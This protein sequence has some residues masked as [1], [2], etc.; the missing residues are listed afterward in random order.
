M[1]KN[2]FEGYKIFLQKHPSY[3]NVIIVD[4]HIQIMNGQQ[5]ITKIR[6]FERKHNLNY[7]IPILVTI[8]YLS[9]SDRRRCSNFK[10]PTVL[11]NKPIKLEEIYI[12]LFQ[13]LL[14]DP[15]PEEVKSSE[16]MFDE[17]KFYYGTNTRKKEN[18]AKRILLVESD[19]FVSAIISQF[20]LTANYIV[21]QSYTSLDVNNIYI[22]IYIGVYTN[23]R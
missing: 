7:E 1:A 5:F 8:S 9:S 21:E 19:V 6:D 11:I 3:W 16:Y 17:H 20:L 18:R 12:N 15:K 2:G 22:Y 14:N 10:P 23:R 4:L 13:I